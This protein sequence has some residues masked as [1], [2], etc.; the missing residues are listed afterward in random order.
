MLITLDFMD[1]VVL[2]ILGLLIF[3]MLTLRAIIAV[4]DWSEKRKAKEKEAL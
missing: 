2:C 1:A 3:V 4:M